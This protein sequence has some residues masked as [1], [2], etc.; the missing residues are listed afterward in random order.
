MGTSGIEKSTGAVKEDVR[1][2]NARA[3]VSV[4][5]SVSATTALAAATVKAAVSIPAER[6]SAANP[7][8]IG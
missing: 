3:P 7:S 4:S 1:A 2:T 8:E 5:V 6:P